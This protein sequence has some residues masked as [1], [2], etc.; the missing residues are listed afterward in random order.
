MKRGS[1]VTVLLKR[2]YLWL[3]I[4]RSS[5]A[6][7]NTYTKSAKLSS[8]VLTTSI[9]GSPRVDIWIGNWDVLE[10]KLEWLNWSMSPESGPMKIVFLSIVSPELMLSY[11]PR[12]WASFFFS[13]V[14]Y[15]NGIPVRLIIYP[16]AWMTNSLVALS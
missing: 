16:E 12:S 11:P 8:H 6:P 14:K 2:V 3:H 7:K 9:C 1:R 4:L 15:V 5:F 10:G 13:L